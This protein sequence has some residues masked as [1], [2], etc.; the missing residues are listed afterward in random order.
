MEPS[1]AQNASNDNAQQ[2]RQEH[3]T[4]EDT[5]DRRRRRRRRDRRLMPNGAPE[6]CAH[7]R[8]ESGIHKSKSMR[9]FRWIVLPYCKTLRARIRARANE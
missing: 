6:A 1:A 2:Q 5:D 9:N 4:R 3:T 7:A 8:A